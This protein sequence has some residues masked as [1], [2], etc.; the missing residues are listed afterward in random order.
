MRLVEERMETCTIMDKTTVS[1]GIGGTTVGYKDGAEILA[2]IVPLQTD[3]VKIAE[4]QGLKRLYNVTTNKAV[5]LAYNDIIRRN[6]G[7]YIRI[8]SPN[9]ENKSPERASFSYAV[10]PA[11][12]T[13]LS[14]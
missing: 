6:D 7:S 2:A 11:E 14:I 8:T 4:A 1:D 10:C 13:E 9:S 3:E 5:R 12:A